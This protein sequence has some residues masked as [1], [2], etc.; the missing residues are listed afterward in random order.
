[1]DI[2]NKKLKGIFVLSVLIILCLGM[3][4]VLSFFTPDK[5]AD[6]IIDISLQNNIDELLISGYENESNTSKR[7]F[8]SERLT[9]LF[10]R[11]TGIQ[12]ATLSDVKNAGTRTSAQFRGYGMNNGK[13]IVVKIGGLTWNAVYLSTNNTASQDPILTFWLTSSSIY[14]EWNSHATAT[15]GTYP[16]NMYGRSK[17]RA[18][19]LNN[20]G[21]YYTSNS[22]SGAVT[23]SPIENHPFAVFTAENSA[24]FKGSLVEF[25][26][27]PSKV[28]WQKNIQSKVTNGS[29][30]NYNND[31]YGTGI[32]ANTFPNSLSYQN[33]TGNSDWTSDRIWL[34]AYAE[35][36]YD[37]NTGGLWNL[38]VQ[39]KG[40]RGGLTWSRSASSSCARAM[41]IFPNGTQIGDGDVLTNSYQVRP[42][43]HLN[44]AKAAARSSKK[45]TVSETL[46]TKPYSGAEQGIE[47]DQWFTGADLS[48]NATVKYLDS[49]T[50]SEM[51]SK[52]KY[53]G[54]Y[55]VEITLN[56]DSYYW[57]D[58]ANSSTKKI[59]YNIT[60]KKI[61]FPKIIDGDS[62][63]P[64]NG[65]DAVHF[66][67]ETFEDYRA[68]IKI[69]IPSDYADVEYNDISQSISAKRVGKYELTV[70][71]ED[72]ANTEW[73]AGT[74]KLEF[75]VSKAK[76]G[77]G[78]TDD[79]NGSSLT[80]AKGSVLKV[81][82]EIDH[83]MMPHDNNTVSVEVYAKADR[84]P[85]VKIGEKIDLTN[86]EVSYEIQLDLTNLRAGVR[87]T[88][89]VRTDSGDYEIELDACTLDVTDAP[90]RTVL[91]WEL[92]KNGSKVRGVY[93]DK[94]L[95][96]TD[97]TTEL[98]DA[99]TYDAKAYSLKV[100]V[101]NGYTLDSSYGIGGYK[102]E[103]ENATNSLVGTNA[104]KYKTSISLKNNGDGTSEIYEIRWEIAKAKFDLSKVKWE[105]DGKLPYDREN[106]STAILDPKTMPEGLSAEYENNTGANVGDYGSAYVSRFVLE[107][108]Y[109]ENYVLP[110]EYDPTTYIDLEGEFEWTK[111]WNIVKARIQTG[112]WKNESVT[113]GNGKA[114]DV[115]VLRD[116][117]AEG[118]VEY[119]YYETDSTG[120]II[121]E[122]PKS[123]D[124]IEYSESDVKFYIAKPVLVDSRNYEFDD[125]N[126]TSKWFKVGRALTKVTV[127]LESNELEYNTNPRHVKLNIG[128]DSVL[129][130]NAFE[131][132]YYEGY[133]RLNEAPK[134]VGVY[135]AEIRLKSDYADKYEIEGEY[136]YEFEIVKAKIAIDWNT[137]AKPNV[138]NL[139][140]GQIN[141]I[142]YEIVDSEDNAVDYKDLQAGNTYRIRAKIK[143]SEKNHFIF[144]DG[145]M[146][147]DWQEFS[148]SANDKLTD[149]NDSKN[150]YYPQVD[151]D[152]PTDGNEPTSPNGEDGDGEDGNSF[153]KVLEVLKEWWQVIASGVSIVLII[154]F[155]AKGIGYA[156]KKK[157]NKRIVESKYKTYYVTGGTGLFGLSMTNWTIIASV[158]MGLAVLSFVFMLIEKRGYKKSLRN[159]DEAK[160]EFER[161]QRDID[162]RKR[163]TDSQRRDEDLKMILMSMLGG[164][165]GNMQSG[166]GQPQGYAYN[167]QSAVGMEEMRCMINDAVS[168]MLP[169]VQQYLPQQASNNDELVQELIEQNKR[170]EERIEK[171]MQKLSEQQPVEK[172]IERETSGGQVVEKVI[173]VSA[174]DEKIDKLMKA[175][176]ELIR[177]Q[178]LLMK[179]MQQISYNKN[180]EKEI[181]EKIVELPVE[182]VIEKEVRVE[183]PVEKIVEVPVEVEKIVE[184]EVVK[185]VKV[186]VPIEVEKV[187]EKIVEIP[188][189]KPA[190]K[191]KATASRLT[192]DEAYAK[193]SAKQKKF[194]D[195][196]KEYAMSKEKCKEKKSTY[197][198][199]LG[200][201]SVNPLVKLTIKK[202]CTVALFKMEDEYMKDIRRNAGSEGTKVKVKETELIVGDSQALAT[203]KEMIDLREDQIERY[204]DFLKEQRSMRNK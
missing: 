189:E 67:L 72:T 173:Q 24:T 123:A 54:E 19:T 138:L 137:Q 191:A 112:S 106:G 110:D 201:S 53:V 145:S 32:A 87:Y 25:I 8:D 28:E 98:D 101:P 200:Q 194:F 95:S 195:T 157:E 143:D 45:V 71:L 127:E 60:K 162:N 74:H 136:D 26:D 30:K 42:A 113:D 11:I 58:N 14:S 156:S 94:L 199:L 139:K 128:G 62:V 198:I 148:V 65:G 158:L 1:M 55:D 6:A 105:H 184:K 92:Y 90:A 31:A 64:Y 109:E 96:D 38:S 166:Q 177:N 154:I 3:A 35:T 204:N 41:A 29:S 118:V 133:T 202:D 111:T 183:V 10:S 104:D 190:P 124:E 13:E 185:E 46:I 17:M 121:D 7:I 159:L 89:E 5:S 160:D 16:S 129:P 50:S 141:G 66:Q 115:K 2:G 99:I 120:K 77:I 167:G 47:N 20:G 169:N 108:G 130:A 4:S 151:P 68:D 44:L 103:Y 85:T 165:A 57:S 142:E 153:E 150:P 9:E 84:L 149:S 119:E 175:N 59:A 132:T 144:A 155:T 126:A 39:Q 176:E 88:L 75:E 170:N 82:L 48:A 97:K 135:R 164:N 80:G 79:T 56:S 116:P 33:K 180:T 117:L 78:I 179:Q 187:V 197:Y 51:T 21:T 203:A 86:A 63:L 186:E 147:T 140:Y 131:I 27:T 22:G 34:P 161:N 125:A 93:K 23:A 100:K 15:D 70:T 188:V 37:A 163:E 49:A 134:E 171:L 81:N 83:N 40:S 69:E 52:P 174:N 91:T 178:E 168:A 76:V 18:V 114:F 102:V 61:P 192:L 193:L 146:E 36:G 107:E 182:K 181:V 43:F 196:L 172:V 73:E 12:N 152:L 122:T